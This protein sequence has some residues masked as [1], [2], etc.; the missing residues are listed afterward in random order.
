ML[1][2][3]FWKDHVTSRENDTSTLTTGRT[4]KHIPVTGTIC[5]STPRTSTNFDNIEFGVQDAYVATQIYC[6]PAAK[7]RDLDVLISERAI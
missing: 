6:L 5:A 7:G 4:I 1:Y 2:H 3:N